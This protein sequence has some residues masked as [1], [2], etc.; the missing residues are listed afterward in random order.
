MLPV[1]ARIERLEFVEGH[2]GRL[3]NPHAV[4]ARLDDIFAGANRS[5]FATF[6]NRLQG[7]GARLGG[8]LELRNG[9]L[10]VTPLKLFLLQGTSD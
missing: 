3:D 7:G 2:A 5:R 4:V 1:D 8:F 6:A 9:S 10:Q